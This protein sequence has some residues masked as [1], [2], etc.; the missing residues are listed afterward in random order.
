MAGKKRE[1]KVKYDGYVIRYRPDRKACW[2][3]YLGRMQ[4]VGRK[5][6]LSFLFLSLSKSPPRGDLKAK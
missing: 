5:F 6:S 4:D 2:Q 1:D 3:L